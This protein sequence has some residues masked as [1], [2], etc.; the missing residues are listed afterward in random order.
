MLILYFLIIQYIFV[1][2]QIFCRH[3]LREKLTKKKDFFLFFG[4]CGTIK[5]DI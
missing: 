2:L 5:K 1:P 4:R 3:N